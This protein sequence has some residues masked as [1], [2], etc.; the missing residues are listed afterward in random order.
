MKIAYPN[1][2]QKKAQNRTKEVR[3]WFAWLPVTI[4]G[5]ARWLEYVKVSGYWYIGASGNIRFMNV[6]FV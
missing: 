1:E 5:E 6:K 3:T 4:N 2:L